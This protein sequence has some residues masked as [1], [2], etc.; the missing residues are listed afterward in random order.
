MSQTPHFGKATEEDT[1]VTPMHVNKHGHLSVAPDY[2]SDLFK[3]KLT[4]TN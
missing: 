4:E 3:Q 2:Q 1:T